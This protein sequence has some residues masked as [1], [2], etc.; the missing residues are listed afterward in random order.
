MSAAS[1]QT[2]PAVIDTSATPTL[3]HDHGTVPV[4]TRSERFKSYDPEAFPAVT[5]REV[6]WKFTPVDRI[7]H[8][9]TGEL[10]GSRYPFEQQIDG[11]AV[12][13]WID[14]DDSRIG[15]AG[16]P[17]EP[18]SAN[19]WA[20]FQEALLVTVTGEAV[21]LHLDRNQLGDTPRAAHTVI[22]AEENSRGIV[23]LENSGPAQLDE[24]VE[25]ILDPGAQ[26]TVVTVHE[27]D[28]DAL[29]VASHFARLGH[30]ASL[31]HVAVSLGG[32]LVRVNPSVHLASE[33]SE[34]EAFGVYFADAG[35]HLEHQVF[36]NH[37]A[38][39]TRSRVTYKG[40]LQG[41]DARSVWIGDVLIQQTATGTDSYEENR[42]LLLTD[43]TRSDSV[44]NLE[45]ETGDIAGAGHA[46]ASG[47]FDDEQ[48]FYL[49]SRGIPEEEARRLVVRGFLSDIIQKI[50]S[51][52]LEQ[53]LEDAI[54]LELRGEGASK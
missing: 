1:S 21:R 7:R 25:I 23:L 12:I 11:A 27:W 49:E 24:N 31:K 36:I 37:D 2:A 22:H 28:D 4:Q 20:S 30:G 35:Q 54:E 14:R 45:I 17:E 41:T 26:L 38:P 51:P 33:G 18:A 29:H 48:L 16:I 10:D 52:E 8:F 44:P 43:G 53:R 47:R 6:E 3:K 13:E 19:A 5:G 34:I 15:R 50:G 9:F 42:N 40:A 46:S 32:S 39:H